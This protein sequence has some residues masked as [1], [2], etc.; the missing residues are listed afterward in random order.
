MTDDQTGE[1]PCQGGADGVGE[2]VDG[3]DVVVAGEQLN[4][5]A[6]GNVGDEADQDVQ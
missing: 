3:K 5:G 2:Y 6:S 1:G 4:V